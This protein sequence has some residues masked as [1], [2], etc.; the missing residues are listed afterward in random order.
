MKK[1]LERLKALLP[2]RKWKLGVDGFILCLAS[3]MLLL[4]LF[5]LL[6][7]GFLTSDGMHGDLTPVGKISNSHND[8]RRRVDSGI[9]WS[10]V[11]NKDT[12]YEG[13]SIFTGDESAAS[14]ELDSGGKLSIDAKS[15]VVVR[16]R[17]TRLEVDLQYGSMQGKVNGDKPI[18]LMNN[19]Q[20]QELTGKNAEVRIVRDAKTSRTSVQV[21]KGEVSVKSYDAKS[22]KPAKTDS[23]KEDD[24]IQFSA[25]KAPEVKRVKVV[26]QYPANG[27]RLWL[28]VADS[29]TFKWKLEGGKK[30]RFEIA[31]ESEFD[32]PAFAAD[33]SGGSYTLASNDRPVGA[34][35]W[36]VR[37]LEDT[38]AT[39]IP[40]SLT[41]YPDVAPVPVL[42][43]ND[44]TAS[45]DSEHGEVARPIYL[46]WEDK[47]AS[48]E[49]HV[50]VSTKSEFSDPLLIDETVDSMT[51][52]TKALQAGDYFW[53]VLGTHPERKS[54]KWSHSMHFAVREGSKIPTVP[55]LTSTT[56]NYIIPHSLLA[57]LDKN[58]IKRGRGVKPE[59]ITPLSWTKIANAK[60][61]EV[62][63]STDNLFKT[64]I[65]QSTSD[66]T[67]FTPQE[68]KP[69]V[70][71]MRVRSRG[72]DGRSSQP[73]ETAQLTVLV[74]PPA[75]GQVK[76]VV[77]VF[78]NE[79]DLEKAKHEFNFSWKPQAYA[80]NYEFEWGA[81]QEFKR[82][83]KF[84]TSDS[85]RSIVVSKPMDYAYRVRALAADGTPVSPFSSTLLASYKKEVA[86]PVIE[87]K[88]DKRPASV[89]IG[90][91]AARGL[92][93][94]SLRDPRPN[95]PVI[96]LEKAPMFVSF[97]WKPISSAAFYTLQI[98]Q[99]SEFTHI[100]SEMKVSKPTFVYENKLPAGKV[101]WRVRTHTAKEVSAW[102]DIF[103]LNV[104]YQ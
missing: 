50:Q 28:P 24:V 73:S 67:T 27:S 71:Y 87:K 85:E 20:V 80:A 46:T 55:L 37:P 9:A 95:T 33:V 57:Q 58:S 62:E 90:G 104:M 76:P 41:L 17:G 75:I 74:P 14:V 35:Y 83:K 40:S 72:A 99:D 2:K 91:L 63:V 53:R 65:R 52:R 19:G 64:S 38:T 4:S 45:L 51:F 36:R 82:S 100:I 78:K 94:P 70:V 43:L 16:T 32:R 31:K 39:T 103:D 21:V 84:K 88:I 96:S 7:D 12:V 29:L 97:K 48:T 15:L 11:A 6:D 93:I 30:A 13:D 68:V 60:N 79:R 102:S 25:Q 3:L 42:P 89:D 54:E 92:L 23:I 8:V 34:F 69:G 26:L 61:Y 18:V 98:S 44:Q 81:D 5:F 59:N 56:L 77:S 22:D 47:A 86:L 66:E 1:R 49:W 10:Q 101:F